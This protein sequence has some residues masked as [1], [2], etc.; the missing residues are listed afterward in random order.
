[1]NNPKILIVDDEDRNLRLLKEFC[2]HLGYRTLLATN[3]SEALEKARNEHPD[4]ILMDII[5]PEIDGFE[6]TE[7]LKKDN[8]TKDIPVIIVTALS[9]RQDRL[10][11]IAAGADDILTKPIDFEELRLRLRN[12]L[13]RKELEDL[14]KEHNRLLEQKVQERTAQL[15]DAK[16]A[17]ETSFI[18]TIWRL[19]LAAEYKDE[20]TGNHLKRTSLYCKEMAEKIGMDREFVKRI[21]YASPM[22]DI[23]KVGIPDN[24]LLKPG[25]LTQQQWKLMK[26]HTTIGARILQDSK[27]PYLQMAVKICLSHHERWDGSGYPNGLKAEDIPIEGRIMNICDQYDALR[28][29]RPYKP[30]LPHKKVVEILTKGDGRTL[31]EHFDPQVVSIF[32]QIHKKFNDIYE[33]HKD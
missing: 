27:S 9:S 32:K 22:H 7:I 21:Y 15:Q 13:K 30:A 18:E 29:K 24:I 2:E 16:K 3:G 1:M 28:S 26:T 12:T 25:R 33:S 14:L 4:V 11:G 23:G 6:A 10:Q 8:L 17:I 20:E 19:T 5:M 31:P